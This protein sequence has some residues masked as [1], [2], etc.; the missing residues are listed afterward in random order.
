MGDLDVTSLIV[1]GTQTSSKL[2]VTPSSVIWY[3]LKWKDN[4]ILWKRVGEFQHIMGRAVRILRYKFT[5]SL[6]IFAEIRKNYGKI[7]T[8]D[9]HHCYCLQSHYL[10]AL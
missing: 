10:A 2:S 3:H 6:S 5:K 4:C 1:V 9:S 7:T 8:F